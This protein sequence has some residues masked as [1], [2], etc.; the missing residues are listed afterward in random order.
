MSL[1][2]EA[3][4]DPGDIVLDGNPARPKGL[5]AQHP[6]FWPTSHVL[7]PNGAWI[8]V[9]FG[10]RVGFGPGH[11]RTQLPLKKGHTTPPPFRVVS[12]VA[13]LL[14]GSRCHLIGR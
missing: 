7:W 11:M 1:G 6:Q 4:L 9:P 5:G 13:K 8:K 2:T 12:V 14:D 3:D 10:T